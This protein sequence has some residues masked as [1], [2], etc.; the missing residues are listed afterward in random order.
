MGF[1]ASRYVQPNHPELRPVPRD[2]LE[3]ELAEAAPRHKR[4]F[5]GGWAL[6]VTHDAA[7]NRAALERAF[8]LYETRAPGLLDRPTHLTVPAIIGELERLLG[9]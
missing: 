5:V 3:R 7:G 9:S 2:L 8:E 4:L 1:E 6:S